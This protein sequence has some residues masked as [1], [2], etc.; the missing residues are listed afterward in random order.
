MGDLSEIIDNR[1][2]TPNNGGYEPLPEGRYTAV[3]NHAAVKPTS[4]GNGKMVE[5]ESKITALAFEGRMVRNWL[6]IQISTGNAEKDKKTM[7]IGQGKLSAAAKA[8]GLP[9]GI[10]NDSQDFL[11]RD[12]VVDLGV[13]TYKGQ[14]TNYVKGYYKLTSDKAEMS[15]AHDVAEDD[16]PF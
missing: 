7:Q 9:P 1:D 10:P 13:T 4:K 12:H 5:L 2:V 6:V 3:F 11:G 16:I 15:Q 14:P 8:C